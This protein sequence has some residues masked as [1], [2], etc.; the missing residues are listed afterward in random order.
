MNNIYLGLLIFPL[1]F[2]I[3][4]CL[5]EKHYSTDYGFWASIISIIVIIVFAIIS[6]FI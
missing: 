1:L 2:I 6:N 4:A 5:K 3:R